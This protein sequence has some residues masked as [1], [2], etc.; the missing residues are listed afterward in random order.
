MTSQSGT[1]PEDPSFYPDG[2]YYME[3]G[4]WYSL[5]TFEDGYFYI[6]RYT[7]TFNSTTWALTW[8]KVLYRG[9][10]TV[11][12]TATPLALSAPRLWQ[13]QRLTTSAAGSDADNDLWLFRIGFRNPATGQTSYAAVYGWNYD[14]PSAAVND[15]RLMSVPGRWQITLDVQDWPYKTPVPTAAGAPLGMTDAAWVEVLPGAYY[16]PSGNAY[17]SATA[18]VITAPSGGA[19]RLRA[20]QSA[21]VPVTFQVSGAGAGKP[22]RVSLGAAGGAALFASSAG[23]GAGAA[24]LELVTTAN[25][26][27]TVWV[28]SGDRARLETALYAVAG[29]GLQA[30]RVSTTA[31]DSDNDGMSDAMEQALSGSPSAVAYNATTPPIAGFSAFAP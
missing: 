3:T 12:P 31:T 22:V 10:A 20:G 23:G 27:V 7:E 16:D 17:T 26:E 30:V 21:L 14:S 25:G 28:S 19:I 1:M 15:T 11:A 4:K 24:F 13:G 2:D 6:I 8:S 18:P 9:P 29:R 5:M